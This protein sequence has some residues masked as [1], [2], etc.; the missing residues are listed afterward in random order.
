MSADPWQEHFAT[1]AE[2]A[3]AAQLG[4]WVFI[5]SEVLLFGGLFAIY[6]FYRISWGGTFR[7]AIGNENSWL[8][9]A[10]TLL[11][12]TASLFVALS[13][14]AAR[15]GDGKGTAGWLFAAVLFACGFLLVHVFEYLDHARRHELPGI[16]YSSQELTSRGAAV[17]YS[18]FWMM[19]GLHFVHVAIGAVVLAV[20]ATRA[21][22][23]RYTREYHVPVGIA[24]MYWQLVDTIWMF[25][26]PLFYCA[27]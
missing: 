21:L 25:L 4:M 12:L 11:L 23:G 18:L 9:G 22:R 17:F 15:R 1:P 20:I 16:W 2:Q 10:M 6:A 5:A 8:G 13:E 26:F 7:A 27:R 19:T 14:Q 3:H 24:G